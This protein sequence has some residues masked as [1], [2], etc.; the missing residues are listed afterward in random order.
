MLGSQVRSLS[1]HFKVPWICMSLETVSMFDIDFECLDVH[2]IS[3]DKMH[4]E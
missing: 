2:L 3:S 1:S 4:V